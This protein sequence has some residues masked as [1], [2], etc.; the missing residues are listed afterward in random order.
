MKTRKLGVS[1]KLTLIIA[2][3]LIGSLSTLCILMNIQI[4]RLVSK[5][6]RDHA[7][8]TAQAAAACLDAD[9]VADICKNGA[10]A[11]GWQDVYDTLTHFREEAG[12][13]YIHGCGSR[14]TNHLHP[15]YGSRRSDRIWRNH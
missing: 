10:D 11:D 3:V 4:R 13:E 5:Q 14:W 2:V 6:I 7:L 15:G 9:E 12:I 1:K 8:Y